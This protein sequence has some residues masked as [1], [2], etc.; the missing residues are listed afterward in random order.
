MTA[1]KSVPD[2]TEKA[3]NDVAPKPMSTAV[4][5]QPP[6][7]R[8][9]NDDA[10]SWIIL[11]AMLAISIG[12]HVVTVVNLP[13]SVPGGPK[14]QRVEM[15]FYEPPPPP[16]P[17]V[18]EPEPP[19]PVEPPKVKLKPPP[20]KV[21]EV[22]P[23]PDA[24][25]PPNEEPPPEA[26]TKPVPLVVGISMSSTTA[27]G[28]FAVGVGNTTYGKADTTP[29]DPSKVQAYRA[30]KY[31]PPG[32]ADT[33]PE[34]ANEFKPPYPEEAKKNDIEG[35]VVLKITVDENGAVIDA[36]VVKGLGFGLDEA[37]VA[38]IRKFKFK[39]ATKGGEAVGTTLTYNFS[40]FLD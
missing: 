37:S 21:A 6:P 31:V 23:P 9:S 18:E 8:A 24:P 10:M 12:T 11:G 33:Q 32:G 14:N 29:T 1:F 15:E 19:K 16:P 2:G 26:S 28:T 36:K 25:P 27:G 4:M 38:A 22:K 30:P 7:Q 35:T 20:V 40:W 34:V 3:A 39:P 17:K 13:S 5:S